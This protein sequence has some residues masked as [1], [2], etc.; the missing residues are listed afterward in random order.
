M[1]NECVFLCNWSDFPLNLYSWSYIPCAKSLEG[2]QTRTVLGIRAQI[3]SLFSVRREKHMDYPEP[4]LRTPIKLEAST[5]LLH[6]V[7]VENALNVWVQ[8]WR[9]KHSFSLQHLKNV[10]S[11]CW[12]HWYIIVSTSTRFTPFYSLSFHS[13]PLF[14]HRSQPRPYS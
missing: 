2:D 8:D 9:S 1:K 4:Q 13:S 12:M 7:W 10:P 11:A 14:K 5:K 6:F 3:E